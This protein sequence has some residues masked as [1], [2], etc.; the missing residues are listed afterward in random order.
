MTRTFS[1][2]D[3]TRA[4]GIHINFM[5]DLGGGVSTTK[6][7]GERG[8]GERLVIIYDPME[9]KIV[10]SGQ[11]DA[12]RDF[13]ATHKLRRPGGRH[14]TAPAPPVPGPVEETEDRYLTIM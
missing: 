2:I 7:T 13:I 4:Q 14:A 5:A 8:A 12:V 10:V 6:W 1:G 11:A 3:R 9:E